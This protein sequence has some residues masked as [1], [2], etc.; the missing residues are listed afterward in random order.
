M[1][2]LWYT[3]QR[4]FHHVTRVWIRI[5]DHLLDNDCS[6]NCNELTCIIEGKGVVVLLKN[7]CPGCVLCAPVQRGSTQVSCFS[8]HVSE[9]HDG[10]I[11]YK[12]PLLSCLP[13]V[14]TNDGPE[15]CSEGRYG[16]AKHF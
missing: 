1:E 12:C 14:I 15:K 6:I 10:N 11:S 13:I 2:C 8:V 3:D 4:H 7:Q 16:R 9:P 5:G